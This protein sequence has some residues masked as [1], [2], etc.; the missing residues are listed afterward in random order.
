[1]MH[2]VFLRYHIKF[3]DFD[4]NLSFSTIKKLIETPL[5]LSNDYYCSKAMASL[6]QIVFHYECPHESYESFMTE[7]GNQTIE[8]FSP[9]LISIA[10]SMHKK[11]IFWVETTNYLSS[12]LVRMQDDADRENSTIQEIVDLLKKTKQD[13]EFSDF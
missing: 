11:K 12:L 3:K 10:H 9:H 13:F 4:L 1:M 6:L 7:E 2:K 5:T 8:L